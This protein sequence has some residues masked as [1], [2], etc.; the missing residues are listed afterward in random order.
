MR[1]M[2]AITTLSHG[3]AE[4]VVSVISNALIKQD[5]S[6]TIIKYFSTDEEYPIENKVNV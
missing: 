3:G 2:F 1:F 6:V 4:R 5:E